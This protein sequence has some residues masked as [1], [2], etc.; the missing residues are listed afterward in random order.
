MKK[1][2]SP[3]QQPADFKHN[4]FKSLKGFAP[5]SVPADK[6]PTSSLARKKNEVNEEDN[7]SL[8][9]QA[10]EGVK[11][12]AHSPDSP[13]APSEKKAA[14][15]PDRGAWGDEQLFLQAMQKIGT[16][17]RDRAPEPELEGPGRRS[18][19]SR[20]K[21]FKKGTLRI[22]GELDLHGYLREEAILRLGQFIAGAFSRGQQAVLVITGKGIN[23]PE[24]PV[25]RGAVEEWLRGKGKEMVA[26]FS[27]A[28]RDLGGSG[29]FV[30]FLKKK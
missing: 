15:K 26:E 2:K 14:E 12:L 24:G 29:A 18:A 11:R 6:K 5:E 13:V 22:S 1:H 10:V 9:F 4:P 23:S 19:S 30:I 28:S 17:L 3:E 20:M 7:E 25:L 16:T 27:P 21:Q 8:F